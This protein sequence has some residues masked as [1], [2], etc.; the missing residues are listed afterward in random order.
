MLLDLIEVFPK[1]EIKVIKETLSR[2]GI[3][4][5]KNRIL[6]PSCYLFEQDGKF[7]VVH[8]KQVFKLT[9]ENY[10]DNLSQEDIGRRNSIVFCLQGW[11]LID[12]PDVSVIEPHNTFVFV[13]PFNQK[14]DWVIEH[15]I[16]LSYLK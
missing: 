14:R 1:V 2:I 12:I 10:F 11:T 3:A 13:L 6:W 9:R 7:Y 8:F 4:D 15:K 16:N 5:K